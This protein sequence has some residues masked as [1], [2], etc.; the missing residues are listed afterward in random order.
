MSYGIKF[1]PNKPGYPHLNGKVEREDSLS[2][3]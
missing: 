2:E 1:K 3:W